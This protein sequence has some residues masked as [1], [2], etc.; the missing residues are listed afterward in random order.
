MVRP[1]ERLSMFCLCLSACSVSLPSPAQD[2]KKALLRRLVELVALAPRVSPSH[3]SRLP[4][5][6][7]C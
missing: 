4:L 7:K 6:L 2:E 5:I 3:L 1:A